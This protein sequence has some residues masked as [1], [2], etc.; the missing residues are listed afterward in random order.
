MA[1]LANLIDDH[2]GMAAGSACHHPAAATMTRAMGHMASGFEQLLLQIAAGDKR[3]FRQLYDGSSPRLFAAA[4]RIL[5]D[6]AL[7]E[8]AVQ[9]AYVRIWRNAA[10]FDPARGVAMAWMGRIVR[11]A[12]LDRIP[13][14]RDFGRIEDVE[15][16]VLPVE[17]PDAR[18]HQCLKKLP[19]V[20]GKALMLM[21]VHGLTHPELAD[22]LGAP[23]GTVKSWVRRGSEALRICIGSYQ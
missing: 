11:N 23:L 6:G 18:V 7:A 5:G 2:V 14:D 22:Y 9:E 15:I 4:K 3:A 8:D 21:Y 1:R 20:Q 12:A 17:P 13:K 16:A 19:E 10:R